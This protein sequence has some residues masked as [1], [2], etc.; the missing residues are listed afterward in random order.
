[1]N[2]VILDYLMPRLIQATDW[3][4]TDRL[5]LRLGFVK[6]WGSF[7]TVYF[8][9][10]N[11]FVIKVY[12]KNPNDTFYEYRE[13]GLAKEFD[14]F[15]APILKRFEN[16]SFYFLIQEKVMPFY[17]LKLGEKLSKKMIH[18]ASRLMGLTR[19]AKHVQKSFRKDITFHNMGMRSNGEF[20]FY[21]GI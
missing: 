16:D 5:L 15:R 8:K 4:G 20:C 13:L 17:D 3:D 14:K 1:M 10:G 12:Q 18:S 7:K 11:S 21:D 9:D 6:N 2:R 19:D